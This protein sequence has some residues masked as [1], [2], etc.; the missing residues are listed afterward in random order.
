MNK[1]VIG[2]SLAVLV[3]FLFI[4]VSVSSA[5]SIDNKQVISQ[6]DSDEDCGC[7]KDPE[8]EICQKLFEIFHLNW[9]LSYFYDEVQKV[10]SDYGLPILSTILWVHVLMIILRGFVILYMA[11]YMGCG[12]QNDPFISNIL[13]LSNNIPFRISE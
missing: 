2:K 4:G 9:A 12:W 1:T 5:I 6:I 7:N 11:D 10:I 13:N 3:I 8:S